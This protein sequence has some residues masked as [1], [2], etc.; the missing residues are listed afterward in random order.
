VTHHIALNDGS[1]DAGDVAPGAT[2]KAVIMPTGGA[3][4]H[5]TIHA[6]MGGSIDAANGGMPPT[7]DGPA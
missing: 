7:C 2:S 5:C 6:N 4:Y 3:N 1:I